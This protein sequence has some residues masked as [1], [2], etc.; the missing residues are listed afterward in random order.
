MSAASGWVLTQ[1]C[2][3]GLPAARAGAP[4]ASRPWTAEDLT[5]I[6]LCDPGYAALLQQ[7]ADQLGPSLRT[8]I[9][10]VPSSKE[11]LQVAMALKVV[12]ANIR[13]LQ[14]SRRVHTWAGMLLHQLSGGWAMRCCTIPAEVVG[15]CDLQRALTVDITRPLRCSWHGLLM[16]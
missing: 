16:P 7:L 11:A 3:H 8:H 5:C 1:Q 4:G 15:P 10:H 12:S 2:M 9:L 14:R 13:L 6:A